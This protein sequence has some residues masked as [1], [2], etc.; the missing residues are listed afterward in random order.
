MLL[1]VGQSPGPG[2]SCISLI[3]WPLGDTMV[4]LDDSNSYWVRGYFRIAS[5]FTNVT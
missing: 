2:V 5:N 1:K 4:L 3:D